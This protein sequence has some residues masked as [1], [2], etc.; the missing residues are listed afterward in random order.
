M[1]KILAEKNT[2]IAIN[3]LTEKTLEEHQ[4]MEEEID[5]FL[6]NNSSQKK[7]RT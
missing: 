1:E 6:D 5:F 2:Q 7:G 3:S 4:K